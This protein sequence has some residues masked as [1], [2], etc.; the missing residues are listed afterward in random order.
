MNEETRTDDTLD[1]KKHTMMYDGEKY[2][3]STFPGEVFF[4]TRRE[5][6]D[7]VSASLNTISRFVSLAL[8]TQPLERV[9]DQLKKS[10]RSKKDIP[11][12]LL[13]I[14]TPKPEE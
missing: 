8:Q 10:S 1:G 6:H 14:L 9:L 11:G 3:I 2:Y 5:K 13:K 12:M 4:S 7:S